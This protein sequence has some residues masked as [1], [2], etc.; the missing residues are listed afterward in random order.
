MLTAF[1]VLIIKWVRNQSKD[2]DVA[3]I[4]VGVHPFDDLYHVLLHLHLWLLCHGSR[5]SW[6]QGG[7]GPN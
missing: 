1:I 3:D 7:Q 2:D 5:T 6:H 4:V